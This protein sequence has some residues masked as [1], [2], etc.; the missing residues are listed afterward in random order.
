MN[1]RLIGFLTLGLVALVSLRSAVAD[2]LAEAT[3]EAG[4]YLGIGVES[5]HP[6]L[7]MH[8]PETLLDGQGV[9][10]THVAADS[11]A[12]KAGL[13][14]HEILVAYDGQKL[15][16]PEQLVKLVHADKPGHKAKVD[17]VQNGQIKSLE[18]K[19]GT[20]PKSSGKQAWAQRW[21]ERTPQIPLLKDSGTSNSWKSFD[22]LTLRKLDGDRFNAEI[23]YL[24]EKGATQHHVYEGSREEIRQQV[25]E[26][27]DLPANEREHLLRG[28]NLHNPEFSNDFRFRTEPRRPWF[29]WDPFNELNF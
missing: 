13:K 27:K 4:G 9:T 6:A 11:L 26:T 1:K 20:Q 2:D 8:L 21:W 23:E 22:S 29:D 25:S 19:L 3:Q 15:F 16:S 12:A 5:L 28:L 7:V 10:I 17:V 24:D 18:V 14:T